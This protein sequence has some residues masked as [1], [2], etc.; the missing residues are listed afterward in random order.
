MPGQRFARLEV[1]RETETRNG[2]RY[3]LCRCDCG[4]EREFYAYKIWSGRTKSCG[5]LGRERITEGGRSKAKD[6]TGLRFGRLTAIRKD[7][8]KVKGGS[9][10][11]I[12]ACECG[13]D[14]IRVPSSD[15][16]SGNTTSCGCA[17]SE[18]A[19]SLTDYNKEHHTI[20]GAFVP[21]LRQK[22]QPNNKTG[23][24]GVSIRRKGMEPCNT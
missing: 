22:I 11:W 21:L 15:L 17:M 8:G 7:G 14:N 19:K 20:D 6:L 16:I 24:K 9:L 23:V 5:C 1:I 13:K 12:C 3:V 2:R 4:N 18:F 10:V